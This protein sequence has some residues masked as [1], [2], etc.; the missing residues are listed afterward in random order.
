MH[1]ILKH[2]RQGRRYKKYIF[3]SFDRCPPLDLLFRGYEVTYNRVGNVDFS[4]FYT[5]KDNIKMLFSCPVIR[6][7][8]LK[9]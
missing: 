6:K 8:V 5:Y 2:K 7:A 4:L 3:Y 1:L 9:V